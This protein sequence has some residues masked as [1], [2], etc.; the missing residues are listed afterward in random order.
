MTF[1]EVYEAACDCMERLGSARLDPMMQ[2]TALSVDLLFVIRGLAKS[3]S[4]P[5]NINPPTLR[6]VAKPEN[7]LG[8]CRMLDI[9]QGEERHKMR[10]GM[11][12]KLIT[13]ID[14]LLKKKASYGALG[15]GDMEYLEDLNFL[16][17]KLAEHHRLALPVPQVDS[18]KNKYYSPKQWDEFLSAVKVC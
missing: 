2:R 15:I 5:D 17:G 1:S 9:L 4:D 13:E 14:Q 18:R 16:L 7:A 12:L 8:F 6:Y 10:D 11:F 3:F